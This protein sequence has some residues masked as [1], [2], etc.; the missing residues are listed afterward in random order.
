MIKKLIMIGCLL[1]LA[2]CALFWQPATNQPV[3]HTSAPLKVGLL[4]EGKIYD[5]GWDGQAFRGLQ[6]IE[7]E[8]QAQIEC[9]EHADKPDIQWGEA[10]RLADQGYG[11][12]FGNGR[13]FEPIFNKLAVSYPNTRFVFFNGNAQGSNVSVINFTPESMGYFSGM[14]A[15][16]MTKSHKVGLIPAYMSMHEI[17]PF[18]AAVKK[19]HPKNE[20]LI[21]DV[22]SWSDGKKAGDIARKMIQAGADVLAPMGD[23][24]NIDVIMEAHHA[25]R[26]AIGYIS[27]QSFV[28]KNTVITSVVQ[29]VSPLYVTVAEQYL[30]GTLK[31]GD[32]EVDFK[33]GAQQ[34]GTFGPMVPA[35][36]KEKINREL[37]R[38]KQGDLV[39]HKQTRFPADDLNK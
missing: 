20:V 11:L 30:S 10:K 22:G 9:I 3:R 36:V 24:F 6:K 38:Y 16:M 21:Q 28:S 34:L 2:G 39:I 25:G 8:Y 19:Q 31:S 7:R 23:G 18:V 29:N 1:L 32:V 14:I 12:I 17:E 27:D 15:G 26:L 13:S 5:Q 4:V 37:E 33:D 35:E